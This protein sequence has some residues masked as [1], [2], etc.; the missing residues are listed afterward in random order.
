MSVRG[1]EKPD[2]RVDADTVG[3]L[4]G[5]RT[6]A[7]P[8]LTVDGFTGPLDVLLDS[9]RAQKIDLARLS[10][11]AFVRAMEQAPAER[12]RRCRTICAGS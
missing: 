10:I 4:S 2:S 9:A 7:A 8:I 12:T 3:P 5:A 1:Y 11:A 6:D